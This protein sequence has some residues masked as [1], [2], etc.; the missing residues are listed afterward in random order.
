MHGEDSTQPVIGMPK[1][2]KH[3][4]L[5]RI[6]NPPKQKHPTNTVTAATD[7]TTKLRSSTGFTTE[8]EIN[9]IQKKENNISIPTIRYTPRN[10]RLGRRVDEPQPVLIT[11]G[12]EYEETAQ[13]RHRPN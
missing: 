12:E 3:T 5:E 4:E 2:P 8:L 7:Q 6:P 11:I 1:I 10:G 13:T 9:R